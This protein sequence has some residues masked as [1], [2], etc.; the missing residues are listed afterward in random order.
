M[1]S[2][3]FMGTPT[4]KLRRAKHSLILFI[5]FIKS[6]FVL[7]FAVLVSNT[8]GS[9]ASRLTRSLTFAAAA[10]VNGLVKVASFKCNYLFHN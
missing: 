7:L 6:L 1:K 10:V 9:L 8:A 3:D 4:E 5:L 2:V